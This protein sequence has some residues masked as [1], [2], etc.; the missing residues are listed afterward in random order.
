MTGEITLRGRVLPIGG[1]K[2]KI[3]AAKQLGITTIIIPEKNRKD[4]V[5]IPTEITGGLE[6]LSYSSCDEVLKTALDLI[7]PEDFMKVVGQKS[8]LKV[9]D[10]G[11]QISA[12]K[13]IAN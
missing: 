9:I 11:E 12:V 2:E 1:L 3:L 5:K 7:N 13:Q 10:G 6:I 8:N 4:L